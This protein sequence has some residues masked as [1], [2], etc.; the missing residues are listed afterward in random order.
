MMLR[1][2]HSVGA[3][4]LDFYCP[5]CKLAVELDGP[6]HFDPVRSEGDLLRSRYLSAL[7]LRVLR[8][9]KPTGF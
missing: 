6:N 9:E 3:Y 2:Q 4:V 8:F 5:E 1:R 7:N